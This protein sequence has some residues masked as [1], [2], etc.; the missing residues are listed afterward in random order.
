M[1]TI[2]L[3]LISLAGSLCT[4][5]WAESPKYNPA[6]YTMEPEAEIAL[7]RSAAPDKIS[8][9]ATVKILT[10]SGY[11]E[12]AKGDNGFTC[13]VMRGWSVPFMRNPDYYAKARAPICYDPVASRTVLP[14][15]ELCAKLGLEGK[16]V[17]DINREVAMAYALGELPKIETTAFA[18]MWSADQDLGPEAK[19][20]HPHMMV[21]A[22]YYKNSMLG[23]PDPAG[24]LPFVSP[25]AG[26]PFAI[27]IIA[28]GD[29]MAVKSKVAASQKQ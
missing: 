18:Y 7:A 24:L 10:P 20:W 22:P 21:Y 1:K 5:L 28:V 27:V 13:I 9:Q 16:S 3:M 4:P 8:A 29:S 26:T 11:K 25:D 17:N 23:D 15:Q 19:H 6:D 12:A 2:T 14:Y